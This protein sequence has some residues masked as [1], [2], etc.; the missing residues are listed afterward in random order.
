ML[1]IAR[2]LDLLTNNWQLDRVVGLA[3]LIVATTV[4]VYYT[5]W[6]LLM[7]LL[8]NTKGT[9]QRLQFNILTIRS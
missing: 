6:T 4:F 7:V 2:P 8:P 5:V 1:C 9:T 3:M